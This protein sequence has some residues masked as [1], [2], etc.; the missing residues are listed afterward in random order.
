MYCTVVPL[1]HSSLTTYSLVQY[2]LFLSLKLVLQ[3]Q[4]HLLITYSNTQHSLLTHHLLTAPTHS[5]LAHQSPTTYSLL[6]H[7]SSITTYSSFTHHLLITHHLLTIYSPLTHRSP[8]VFEAQ[9]VP[10]NSA[11]SEVVRGRLPCHLQPH[12]GHWHHLNE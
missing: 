1:T 12:R 10:K 8:V 3:F 4:N 7:H 2:H 9:V 5:P 11:M 6:T